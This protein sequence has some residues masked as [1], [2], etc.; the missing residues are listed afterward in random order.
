MPSS[1]GGLT[2][3]NSEVPGTPWS[4][5]GY[6]VC[7]GATPITMWYAN[8]DYTWP[9][10]A[11]QM[12]VVSTDN[13]KDIP[14]GTGARTVCIHYLDGNYAEKHEIIT[15]NGTTVVP[16]VATDI[17]R[18]NS[19]RVLTTGTDGKNT[20]TIS[21]RNLAD[22]PVYS[23]IGPSMN[24][25]MACF[26]TVPA[27]KSL[28]VQSI[29]YS[30]GFTAAGKVVRFI[31]WATYDNMEKTRLTAGVQFIPYSN[32]V[33]M[34]ASYFRSLEPNTVLPEKTDIKVTV[35]GEANAY[36]AVQLRGYLR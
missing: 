32:V 14:G 26:Y 35:Q 25:A 17:F 19:F 6:C 18:I 4:K 13:A 5:D 36:C 9:T 8:T 7:Q 16:T 27:G 15:L 12:E 10:V 3:I 21:I 28:V 23:Q 22:T 30:S 2:T 24:R 1:Q 29:S 31:N 11:Q 20:G 34:D 33:L